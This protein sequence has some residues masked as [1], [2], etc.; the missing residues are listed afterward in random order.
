MQTPTSQD[1]SGSAGAGCEEI[2]APPP[3]EDRREERGGGGCPAPQ[4]AAVESRVCNR[5]ALTKCWPLWLTIPES[6]GPGALSQ[7]LKLPGSEEDPTTPVSQRKIR[8]L[9]EAV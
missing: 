8:K 7:S 6:K 4:E 3:R 1:S 2:R 9:T 5:L